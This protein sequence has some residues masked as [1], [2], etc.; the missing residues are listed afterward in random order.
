MPQVDFTLDDI[1][2]LLEADRDYNQKMVASLFGK[3]W[4]DNIEPHLNEIHV[5][6][7]GLREELKGIRRE[8]KGTGR[9]VAQ[10]TQ[11]IMELRAV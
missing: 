5:D 8:V 3:F 4:E 9:I 7:K 6:I 2:Q 10:H 1:R 11:D